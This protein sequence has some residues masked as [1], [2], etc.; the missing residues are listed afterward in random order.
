VFIRCEWVQS[1]ERG[2]GFTGHV[3]THG[4]S[5][6]C[7][8]GPVVS[9]PAFDLLFFA[10]SLHPYTT[11]MTRELLWMERVERPLCIVTK[12]SVGIQ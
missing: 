8:A 1:G 3:S 6:H 9:A 4:A 5:M 11:F 7:I 12:T 2:A 10:L